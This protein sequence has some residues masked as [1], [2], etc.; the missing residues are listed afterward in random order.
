[1]LT[2]Q[3]GFDFISSYV[4]PY[5]ML[6]SYD[7][8]LT[9]YRK[10]LPPRGVHNFFIIYHLNSKYPRINNLKDSVS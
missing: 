9:D 3:H 6:I 2:K 8:P 1:M 7:S 4:Y 10:K 5:L